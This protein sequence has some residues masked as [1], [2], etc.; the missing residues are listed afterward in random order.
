MTSQT[1]ACTQIFTSREKL[2][3][4]NKAVNDL[5]TVDGSGARTTKTMMIMMPIIYG[6]FSFFYS[7]SFSIYMITNT[8]YSILTTLLINKLVDISFRRKEERGEFA[9]ITRIKK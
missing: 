3:P 2:T 5:S 6:L 9:N 4:A 8:I 7:A 1:K